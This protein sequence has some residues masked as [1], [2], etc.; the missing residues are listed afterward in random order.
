MKQL[1]WYYIESY[2]E[3]FLIRWVCNL[4]YLMNIYEY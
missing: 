2:K 3:E 1:K 4:L